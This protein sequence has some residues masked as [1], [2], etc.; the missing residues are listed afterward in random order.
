[1]RGV[2][3][4][5]ATA[6][7]QRWRWLYLRFPILPPAFF[8]MILGYEACNW[9]NAGLGAQRWFSLSV[10]T[11]W[12]WQIPFLPGSLPL[13]LSFI[14]FYFLPKALLRAPARNEAHYAAVHRA[15][16]L[17]TLVSC[18]IFLL[19]PTPVELRHQAQVAL[20]T[21]HL[22]YW[23]LAGCRGLF[24]ID[25]EFNAWPSLHVSQPLLIML[26]VS[27]LGLFTATL[28][29]LLWLHW[30]LVTVSVLTMKQHYLWDVFSAIMLALACWHYW[31]SPRLRAKPAAMLSRPLW[32]S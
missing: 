32:G 14:S 25:G 27:Q 22:P 30:G 13:Y 20:T 24:A 5:V 4:T 21:S 18:A 6:W 19:A 26:A 11:P 1:M 28:R 10:A 15:L 12:D 16:Q 31:L 23:L 3:P 9:I 2:T 8:C 17:T 29:R 7:L